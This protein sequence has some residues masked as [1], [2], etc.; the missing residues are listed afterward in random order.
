MGGEHAAEQDRPDVLTRRWEW[1]DNQPDLDP[2][3]LVFI[4]KTWASTNMAR[5]HGRALCGERPR[6]AIF[7]PIE[8]AFAKLKAKLRKVAAHSVDTFWAAVARIIDAFT[9]TEC[10]NYFAS[11]G[12]RSGVIGFCSSDALTV[13]NRGGT[14]AA[15]LTK[16]GG[17]SYGLEDSKNR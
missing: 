15:K 16:N 14:V 2:D 7:H 10:A 4:D 11:A 8:K 13:A 1:F 12:L 9:P 6:T 17:T 3:H 5:R